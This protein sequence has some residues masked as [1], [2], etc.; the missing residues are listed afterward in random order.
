MKYIKTFENVAGNNVYYII[1]IDGDFN[2]F[3]FALD[4][5]NI[6]NDF[7]EQWEINDFN[8][9]LDQNKKYFKNDK[10]YLMIMNNHIYVRNTIT[11]IKSDFSDN[12]FR[13]LTF[14]EEMFITDEEIAAKKYNL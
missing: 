4:K 9:M 3:L 2:K 5:L 14:K 13:L 6:L 7:Y 12:I 1:H 8:S 11:Q 10:L